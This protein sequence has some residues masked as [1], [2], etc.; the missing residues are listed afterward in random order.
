MLTTAL[1]TSC[2]KVNILLR[3]YKVVS[4]LKTNVRTIQLTSFKYGIVN[5]TCNGGN[6]KNGDTSTENIRKFLC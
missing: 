5:N 3:Y 6:F 4:A 2:N 1:S